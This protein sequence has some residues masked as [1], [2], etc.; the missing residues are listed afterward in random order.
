MTPT[1]SGTDIV[2]DLTLKGVTKSITFPAAITV[3][4]TT[5]KI[6]ATTY[7]DKEVFGITEGAG[8]VDKLFGLVFNLTF[9]K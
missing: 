7:I 4:P 1:V 5:L 6:Q 9:T 3:D 2:G 8:M